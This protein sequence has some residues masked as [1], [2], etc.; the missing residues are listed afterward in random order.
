MNYMSLFWIGIVNIIISTASRFIINCLL[1]LKFWYLKRFRICSYVVF[2]FS[3]F[4]IIVI[5]LHTAQAKKIIPQKQTEEI[6][7]TSIIR[8]DHR[9]YF[10]LDDKKNYSSKPSSTDP[11]WYNKIRQKLIETNYKTFKYI[12]S[13]IKCKFLDFYVSLISYY[14]S[15]KINLSFIIIL[16][17]SI[18]ILWNNK[19]NYFWIMLILLAIILAVGIILTNILKYCFKSPRPLII[20]GDGG[21]NIMFEIFNTANS[22][23]SGHTQVAF[24]TCT[25][26]FM[27]VKKYWYWYTILSLGVAFERVYS[28]SHFPFDV[29]V[30]AVIGIFSTFIFVNLF[31]KQYLNSIKE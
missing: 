2:G 27:T 26:M 20:F 10:L 13:D 17:I 31:K 9:S 18:G 12:N 28:G 3:L 25:F 21:V 1:I 5:P 15:K 7:Y 4:I 22:F 14:D 16:I 23:P 8:N 19:K 11:L 6:K 29:L 30:G 24:T